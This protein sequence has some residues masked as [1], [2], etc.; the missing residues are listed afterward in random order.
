MVQSR[1]LW[2]QR[3]NSIVNELSAAAAGISE[4]QAPQTCEVLVGRG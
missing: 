3:N 2:T 4:L 1:I